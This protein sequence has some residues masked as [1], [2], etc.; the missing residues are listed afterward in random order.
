LRYLAII[1]PKLHW[2]L[3]VP[4]I[5]IPRLLNLD[6]FLT[7]DEPL[8]L[9]HARQFATGMSTGNFSQTLGIGYPGVTVAGWAAPV[10]NLTQS[11]MGA[12]AAGRVVTALLTGLLLVV[13]YRLAYLLLGRWPAFVGVALLALDPYSLAYSRLLHIA[14]PLALF[15]A[16]AG[17]S[18]LLWLRH[19]RR[20]WLLLT[21]L[22]T[23]LALLTKS[24]ALLLAPMLGAAVLGWGLSTGRWRSPRWWLRVVGGLLVVSGVAVAIFFMLWPAMWV[25]P[26][27][28][29][30]LTFGKLFRD[31]EAGTGNLGF[32]WM[33]RFVQDPGPLF[34]PLAFLLKSTPWLLVGLILSIVYHA[35]RLTPHASR[36]TPNLKPETRNPKPKTRNPKPETRNPK[37]ETQNPKPET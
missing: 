11:D 25:N 1:Q 32:F 10:V 2:L 30:T 12:Y 7:A 4:L 23:G 26:A 33:G 28:A 34:Y 14:A 5:F 15:M 37:P 3:L 22:F 21:G 31:Q 36:N 18:L 29:L 17:M 27:Q 19:P 20:R 35:S 24:T 8:F 16:L 6:V 9:T 13:L